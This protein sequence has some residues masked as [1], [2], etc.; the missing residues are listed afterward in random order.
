MILSLLWYDETSPQALSHFISHILW[1]V[2]NFIAM[3]CFIAL[4]STG[5]YCQIIALWL[6]NK[7]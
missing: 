3:L 5:V 1:L 7:D 6:Y 4:L 2:V